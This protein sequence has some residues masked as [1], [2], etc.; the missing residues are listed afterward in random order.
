MARR[1]V[2]RLKQAPKCY[3]LDIPIELRLQIYDW[4]LADSSDVTITVAE[5]ERNIFDDADSGSSIRGLPGKYIPIM[6][7]VYNS[8]LLRIGMPAAIPLPGLEELNSTIGAGTSIDSGYASAGTSLCSPTSRGVET[9]TP[10]TA[11]P[12]ASLSLLLTNSQIHA[13]FS[14]HMKHPTAA[15]STLHVTF[16]YGILVLQEL[17]PSLLRHC[18][19]ICIS[20]FYDGSHSPTWGPTRTTYGTI[21]ESAS[22]ATRDRDAKGPRLPDM[23]EETD[24]AATSALA[25]LTRTL[26]SRT[27]HPTLKTLHMRMFYP[28]ENRYGMLWGCENSPVVVALRNTCGGL[29]DMEVWRGRCGNGVILKVEAA[30]MSRGVTTVWRRIKGDVKQEK[31]AWRVFADEVSWG[32]KAKPMV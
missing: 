15:H 11:A 28:D 9:P 22:R 26:L 13:E 24:K 27:A 21:T 12:L 20:G 19:K 7:N 6:Q 18:E 5:R 8:E 30:S 1:P 16:P 14:L 10:H 29:F 23:S 17:Y 25:R 32:T 2:K 31:N 3:F 4:V